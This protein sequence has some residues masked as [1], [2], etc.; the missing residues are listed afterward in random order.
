MNAH[1]LLTCAGAVVGLTLV[2]ACG[3][4]STVALSAA[5]LKASYV[6]KTLFVN[7]HPT[8]A[9]SLNPL[10][11]YTQLV[12]DSSRRGPYEYVS[13]YYGSYA[14][15]FNHPTSTDMIGRL[16]GAGGQEVHQ[17]LARLR[18]EHR[19]AYQRPHYQIRGSGS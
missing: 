16:Q 8:T 19:R 11:H 3:S 7:G 9:A 1:G 18:E 13:N 17:R 10:P 4:G 12:P 2:S 6:G 15:M 14:S 5:P